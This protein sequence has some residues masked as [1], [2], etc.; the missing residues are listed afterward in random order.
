MNDRVHAFGDDALGTHDAVALAEAVRRGEVSPQ[1]LADAAV[2]RARR[3]DPTLRAVAHEGYDAPRVGAPDGRLGGVPS[4]VKDNRDVAGMPTGQGSEAF[5]PQPAATDSP[6]TRQFVGTG[7]SVLGKSRLPE[8]GLNASTEFMTGEP[9][10]NPWDTGRSVGASSGGAAALVAAGVVPLAHANDGGGSIRIPAACAGLVGLKVTR[11]R[12]LLDPQSKPLP[13]DLVVDGVV[14]R[15]VRD[16]ATFLAA[17]EDTYRN[18]ALPPVGLVEG[19]AR[20]RLRVGV[21]HD[22]I[23]ASPDAETVAAVDATAALLEAAGHHVEEVALPFDES[24]GDD[25]TQYW[26]L[27]AE[28]LLDT[29]K[30]TV[31]RGYDRSRADGLAL[32]LRAHHRANLRRT[33]GAVRRLRKAAATYAAMFDRHELIV[34]PTLAHTT[35]EL[36]HLSPRLDF[37]ELIDRLRH[38]VAYTPINN[39]TGAPSVSLPMGRTA[40]GLPIGVQLLG[41]HGDERTLVETAFLLEEAAPFPRIEA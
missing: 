40:G 31:D 8:F 28:L 9:T 17:L 4:F 35:P 14:S 15:T 12:H 33:P 10:R 16:T 23:V 13:I 24:F 30:L 25:F 38:Y 32:G 39:V 26:S 11:G 21:V 18:P 7:L 1:E 37:A 3:V 29:V 20:R 36:G 22:S 27:L 6:F 19:P 41:A 34:S 5:T 2:A